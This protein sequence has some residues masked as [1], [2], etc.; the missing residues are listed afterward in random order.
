MGQLFTFFNIIVLVL[1]LSLKASA[2]DCSSIVDSLRG[3]QKAQNSVSGSLVQNHELMA[4]T[5]LSYSEALTDSKGKA[6]QSIANNMNKI[7]ESFKARGSKAKVLSEAISEKTDELI[8]LAEKCI[9][10]K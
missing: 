5:L 9:S 1:G 10:E 2:S 3:L 7:S 6:H 8:K 4:E